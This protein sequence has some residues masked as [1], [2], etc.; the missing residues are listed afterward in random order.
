MACLG[1]FFHPLLPTFQIPTQRSVQDCRSETIALE[2]CSEPEWA[3]SSICGPD[4]LP[5]WT[6]SGI[7]YPNVVEIV[8]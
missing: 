3:G 2:L 1:G 6:T 5:M 7:A 8:R 4:R